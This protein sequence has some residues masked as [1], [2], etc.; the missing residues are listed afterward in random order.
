MEFADDAGVFEGV[1]HDHGFHEA[2]DVFAVEGDV[3]SIGGDDFAAD[4]KVFLRSGGGSG[5]RR[6]LTAAGKQSDTEER[7]SDRERLS[8]HGQTPSSMIMAG[9]L[10]CGGG[11]FGR[12]K[13]DRSAFIGADA[14]WAGAGW[15]GDSVAGTDSAFAGAA[16]DDARLAERPVD[17]G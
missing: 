14:L 9:T 2:G 7:D 1:V 16:V 3:R 17:D 13:Q 6:G 4:G 5:R 8:G 15:A 10:G 12:T 11:G